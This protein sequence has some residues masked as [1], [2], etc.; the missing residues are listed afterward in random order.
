MFT[1]ATGTLYDF[2]QT[3]ITIGRD[4]GSEW[5]FAP[6]DGGAI[7]AFAAS[8][9]L[10]LVF[11]PAGQVRVFDVA[12]E[13]QIIE[14]AGGKEGNFSHLAAWAWAPRRGAFFFALQ[15]GIREVALDGV[16]DRVHAITGI[17]RPNIITEIGARSGRPR[18]FCAGYTVDNAIETVIL[19]LE[20][21]TTV[22]AGIWG[23]RGTHRDDRFTGLH[24]PSPDGRYVLRHH[25]GSVVR[26][27]PSRPRLWPGGG[28]PLDTHPDVTR[29]GRVRYGL[30]L[31]VYRTE[32]FGFHQRIVTRLVTAADINAYRAQSGWT[33][34]DCERGIRAIDA[35]AGAVDFR[36]WDERSQLLYSAMSDRLRQSGPSQ[37]DPD[38]HARFMLGLLT[39]VT[40]QASG[41]AFDVS[42]ADGVARRIDLD[43]VVGPLVDYVPNLYR[44]VSDATLAS[45]RARL[46]DTAIHRIALPDLSASACATAIAAVA[47]KLDAGLET[48]VSRDNLGFSFELPDQK[49]PESRFFAHVREASEADRPLLVPPLRAM[50]ASYGRQIGTF[51]LTVHEQLQGTEIGAGGY[52][53]HA[54][55]VEAA[56]ALATLDPQAFE[57][58]KPWFAAVDGEHDSESTA[59]VFSAIATTSRFAGADAIRFGLW[60]ALAA[61]QSWRG[62]PEMEALM[63]AAWQQL[64]PAAC[65]AI[66]CEVIHDVSARY[67]NPVHLPPLPPGETISPEVAAFPRRLPD[68]PSV[69]AHGIFEL[70]DPKGGWDREVRAAL[71][72][73]IAA[74]EADLQQLKAAVA[75]EASRRRAVLG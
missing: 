52:S 46:A 56:L 12:D 69:V 34:A 6:F 72:P 24:W 41:A 10:L 4:D 75:A 57:V 37:H 28:D 23:M 3:I 32:P 18:L 40:W 9:R 74:A 65:A 53:E 15:G 73:L 39:G 42:F 48:L 67:G 13:R 17:G 21:G 43:G 51:K 62:T 22:R 33:P 16:I 25:L 7:N 31:D 59:R 66:A 2:D 49:L 70:L 61:Q 68:P 11:G 60:F 27:L 1:V 26:V 47:Q 71:D 19:D 50:M 8:E 29:D 63:Q 54:A 5:T 38:F 64:T 45:F 36:D 44:S 14:V 20:S 35:L 30:A 58:L 55:L